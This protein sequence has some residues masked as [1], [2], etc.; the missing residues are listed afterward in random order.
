MIST[1][2]HLVL[3]WVIGHFGMTKQEAYILLCG[4]FYGALDGEVLMDFSL[5]R[6]GSELGMGRTFMRIHVVHLGIMS[7]FSVSLERWLSSL[8]SLAPARGSSSIPQGNAAYVG[9]MT[10]FSWMAQAGHG[11]K[12]FALRCVLFSA[13]LGMN[14]LLGNK[15]KSACTV[16]SGPVD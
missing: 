14:G 16:Q 2:F 11:M 12:G 3:N 10:A 9:R 15:R 8:V 4:F 5:R 7:S 13:S 6:F 1:C